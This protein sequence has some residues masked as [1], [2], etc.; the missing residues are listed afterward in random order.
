TVDHFVFHPRLYNEW[1][2]KRFSV[3]PSPAAIPSSWNR[4]RQVVVVRRRMRAMLRKSPLVLPCDPEYTGHRD[5]EK[6]RQGTREWL[7]Q[8]Q[9]L[10]PSIVPDETERVSHRH[11]KRSYS[12]S[13]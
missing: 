8:R 11:R 4:R 7:L 10:A 6:R 3:L 13:H 9:H 2:R 5:A 12:H 1:R